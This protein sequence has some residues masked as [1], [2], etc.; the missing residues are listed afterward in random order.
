MQVGEIS[1]TWPNR[2]LCSQAKEWTT[3]FFPRKNTIRIGSLL[4][5]PCTNPIHVPTK[6]CFVTWWSKYVA[7][8][9]FLMVFLVFLV[10]ALYVGTLEKKELKWSTWNV[11][12]PKTSR[13]SSAKPLP[14]LKGLMSWAV[15]HNQE[16]PW[17]ETEIQIDNV[18]ILLKQMWSNSDAG[19]YQIV[20]SWVYRNNCVTMVVVS[21]ILYVWPSSS[22]S[23]KL[24]FTWLLH[25]TTTH[26][27]TKRHLP[28]ALS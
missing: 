28:W 26:D 27:V 24:F 25:S 6:M 5:L 10:E 23:T 3:I 2:L 18:E 16:D 9:G 1:I 8:L 11:G 14:L 15:P 21:K 7:V 12:S 19:D 4:R 13:I 20:V 22:H 17:D